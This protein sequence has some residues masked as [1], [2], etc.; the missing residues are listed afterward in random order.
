MKR[1]T[2]AAL[3]VITALICTVPAS[4]ATG[5]DTE[6]LRQAADAYMS[7]LPPDGYYVSPDDLLKRIE[8]GK[9]DFVLVDC[10]EKIEKYRAGHIPGAIYI[11]AKD[12]AKPRA[13]PSCP[14][15]ET[16]SS[17]ATAATRRARL[18]RCSAC[19]GTRST[20]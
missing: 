3:L 7:A 10:R 9:K 8:S 5:P 20:P 13:S 14:G 12:I 1:F 16:S 6:Q 17:T 11:N 18:W 2:I 15:T 19:S 4:A